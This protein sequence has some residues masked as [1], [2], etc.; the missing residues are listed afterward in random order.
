MEIILSY[1]TLCGL[2]LLASYMLTMNMDN[3]YTVK[4]AAAQSDWN[5]EII[6]KNVESVPH[7]VKG[8]ENHQVVKFLD[9]GLDANMHMGQVSFNSSKLV[10]II[11]YE[12]ITSNNNTSA[13]TTPKKIWL[14]K[15]NNLNPQLY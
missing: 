2:L 5:M 4:Q 6:N 8:H 13:T 7:D 1:I 15:P 9:D 3:N 14:L 12:D 11:S 10:E